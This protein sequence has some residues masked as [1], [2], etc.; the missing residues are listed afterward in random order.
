[1]RISCTGLAWLG[2]VCALPGRASAEPLPFNHKVETYRSKD[3]EMVFSLRLEQQFLAEEFEKS[4]YLRLQALDKNA[5]LIYPPETKFHQK[6]AEFYGRLRGQDKARL[7][8]SYE[9]ISENLDGSRKV[10]VRQ[11]EIEVPIPAKEGGP[12]SIYRE[13][14]QQQNQHFLTLLNYY[15]HETFF[16]YVL[17]QSRDRYGVA[18]PAMP[19]PPTEQDLEENLYHFFT[20]SLA[21]HEALQ[22]KTLASGPQI[23]DLDVHISALSPPALQSAPYADLLEKK[24][25]RENVHPKVH[26]LAR[27]VPE[28][29]YFLH[30]RSFQAAQELMDLTT[31]WGDDVL[32]L[33]AVQSRHHQLQKKFEDQLAVRREGLTKLFQ[34]GVVTEFA[35]TGSDPFVIEGTDV[36]LVFKTTRPD[37]FQK[38]ADGW[39]LQ[40]REKYPQLEQREFNYRG[41]KVEA[42]YTPDRMVSS[43]VVRSGDHVVYSNS[44]FAIRKVVDTIAG[45]APKLYDAVDYRYLTTLLPPVD[46]PQSGYFFASEAFLKRLIGPAAKISEK[47]RMQCHN[48][49][50]MLNNASLFYRMEQG[51]SPTAL[52]ELIEGRYIDSR[53]LVCPHG[54]AYAI[55]AKG[56][57]CSCSLHNRLRYL[58]PNAELTTLQVSRQE[59]QEYERYKQRYQAF[60]QTVFDPIAVRVTVAPRVKFEVCVLPFANGSLYQQVRSWVADK[61]QPLATTHI[62]P[63]AVASLGAVVG[64]KEIAQFLRAIPGVPD[65]LEADPTLTDLSWLGDR[66]SLH[67]CDGETVLEID[68]TRLRALDLLGT[69]ATVFQQS[70]VATAVTATNL[71]VYF[72][73][74]VEDRDK[75][76][77]LLEMLS[78]RIFLKKGELFTLPTALDAYRLPDY[79]NHAMYV[80][81][82]QLYVV[83]VRLHVALV[84]DQLVGAT[85]PHILKEVIDAAAV[86]EPGKPADAHL[87]LRWNRRALKLLADDVQLYWEE[88]ARLA[89]HRN[90]MSIQLLAQL[91]DT[92]IAQ[93]DRLSE[94]KY[95]VTYYCPDHGAYGWD[96]RRDQVMCSVHGNRQFSRQIPT[97]GR[98]TAFTR[99]IDSLDEVVARLRFQDDALIATVEI[100]RAKK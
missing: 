55:D 67:F 31:E 77:R 78:S 36:T 69:R 86:K 33:F 22:R 96:S 97:E 17:L 64:R 90:I 58:T 39:L 30:F 73:V 41:H 45:L 75:A 18:A 2:L 91:Y 40:V 38:E 53:K 8:L 54:G 61:P 87:L 46:D 98:P 6:H 62:A 63:S 42:R 74:D 88:K 3:G 51:R 68:P 93:V 49:L 50:V 27:L 65:V 70:I 56:D 23:G 11:G 12:A 82:F 89:C 19:P 85:K 32:R 29:Q 24:R 52:T 35:I 37:V 43:F 7:R 84:G 80:L 34:D 83:K 21:I 47:R 4:N 26:E 71:P 79:K 28:D 14:A 15:P 94:A 100:A 9:I 44:H 20:G 1:M 76:N 5:Y 72:T 60:W 48:N 13:W 81:S 59:Q 25:T 57:T 16:Q 92:P 66:V 10:T 99:F 95:G